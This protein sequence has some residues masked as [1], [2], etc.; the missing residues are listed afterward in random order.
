M[1]NP[2]WPHT[3]YMVAEY[4]DENGIPVTDE[5][6]DPCEPTPPAPTP[7]EALD[8][9]G[10]PLTDENGDPISVQP[11]EETPSESPAEEGSGSEGNSEETEAAEEEPS[12]P[13]KPAVLVVEYDSK[14]NPRKGADGKFV[15][16]EMTDVPWGY[17]TAT[18]GMKTAGEVI[19]ADYKIS[20]P[21]LLTEIPTGSVLIM[22]D[23]THTFRV[24]VVKMTTY[25]WG[26]NLWVDNIK[27]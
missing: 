15:T 5:N 6:G 11:S 8:E 16:R 17:R 21:M 14:W 27:N 1:F 7:T 22:T 13:S 9:N 25:N 3:F 23:Y 10:L 20:C 19:V 12:E 18:G 2:R 26:T 24:K 4:L